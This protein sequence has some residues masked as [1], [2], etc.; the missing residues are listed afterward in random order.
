[1]VPTTVESTSSL[2]KAVPSMTYT[3][4]SGDGAVTQPG[5]GSASPVAN[6]SGRRG[7]VAGMCGRSV[8]CMLDG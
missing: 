2:L 7:C 4:G 8:G 6:A 1:M 3:R 5:R